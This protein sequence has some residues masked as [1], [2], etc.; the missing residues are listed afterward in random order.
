MRPLFVRPHTCP[1]NFE[2]AGLI[3]CDQKKTPPGWTK[4]K[5][6][7]TA[8]SERQSELTFNTKSTFNG[9][10]HKSINMQAALVHLINFHFSYR[11]C[12][13]LSLSRDAIVAAPQYIMRAFPRRACRQF[14]VVKCLTYM[15]VAVA[16][17]CRA[18]RSSISHYSQDRRPSSSHMFYD[19]NFPTRA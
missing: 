3:E 14:P 18:G 4:K 10:C 1:R 17:S 2:C 11:K 15:P 9:M 16:A 5:N 6:A 13:S 12:E 7:R 19:G 8:P